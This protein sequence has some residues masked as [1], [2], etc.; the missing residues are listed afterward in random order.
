MP[1]VGTVRKRDGQLQRFDD[2]RL[3]ASLRAANGETRVDD[4]ELREAVE[5]IRVETETNT[6]PVDIRDVSSGLLERLRA[7]PE[8]QESYRQRTNDAKASGRVKKQGKRPPEAFSREKLRKALRGTVHRRVSEDSLE[9][10]ATTIEERVASA[11][12]EPV[13]TA[14][15]RQW[16]IDA[17]RQIDPFAYLR[18]LSTTPG[19]DLR[20]LREELIAVQNGLVRKRDGRFESFSQTKLVE[21]IRKATVKRE[22][23]SEAD[24]KEFA[25]KIGARVREEGDPVDSERIGGWVLDW[26]KE[27]D[28]VAFMSFLMV[29]QPPESPRSL[30]RLLE[31]SELSQN[32]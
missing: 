12:P 18:I 9:Q 16:V 3:L 7:H 28:A 32:A 24:A 1:H 17:L 2:D 29:F 21:S 20:K 6:D 4:D 23:I 26:L 5:S 22:T 27:K 31:D 13:S 8:L 30:Q 10:L 14:E 19:V 15:I 25:E 11:D